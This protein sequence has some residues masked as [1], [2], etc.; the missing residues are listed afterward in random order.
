MLTALGVIHTRQEDLKMAE[1][2]YRRV[3][4]IDPTHGYASNNLAYLLA[5]AKGDTNEALVLAGIALD[6][7][8]NDPNVLDTMGWIY[9]Q[10]GSYL[11]AIDFIKESLALKPDNPLAC[12]HLGMALSSNNEFGKARPYFE[13]ALRFDYDFKHAKEIRNLIK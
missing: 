3:L 13:K 9:Y 7:H 10:K 4:D 2:Y 5:E 1:S 8:P 11:N 12:Y 6:K